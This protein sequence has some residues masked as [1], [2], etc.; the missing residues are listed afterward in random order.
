V[1]STALCIAAG[2]LLTA[3]A[4]GPDYQRPKVESPGEWRI[5]YP[6]AAEV[7]NTRWWQQFGDPAL[8]Q[9]VETA[10][11]E[12][13]DVQ[14]ASARVDQFLGVLST[15]RS[16][17]FPQFGYSGDASRNRASQVGPTPISGT[18]PNYSLYQGSLNAAWQ[19]DLFGRV[20]R[21][22]E[23]AQAQVYASEQGR[24]GVIL[25]IVT[26]TATNYV[27]LRSLDRQLEIAQSSARNYADTKELFQLR[28]KGGV[29]SEV[30]LAQIESQYQLA[31]AT[32]PSLEQ[33]IAAQENL[34]SVLLGRNPGAI[35]R[36]KSIDE[37]VPPAIPAGL[38]SELL[39]RRPDILQAEQ[40]LVAVNAN[41]GVAKSLYFPSISITGLFGSLSTAAGDF[42]GPARPGP[43]GQV[44]WAIFTFGAISG[45]VQTAEAA[46]VEAMLFYRS[47]ILNA[48]RETSDAL[49]GSQKKLEEAEAQAR[50]VR[51]LR[52]YAR[53]ARLRFDNGASSYIEVLFA[54]NDLFSAELTSVSTQAERYTQLIN[55]YKAMGGG[56]GLERSDGRPG[57][58]TK[59]KPN[60]P[61][62]PEEAAKQLALELK[63]N[64][65]PPGEGDRAT[66]R[67]VDAHAGAAIRTGRHPAARA[68]FFSASLPSENAGASATTR[69][70]RACRRNK[71]SGSAS[72]CSST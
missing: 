64:P 10:L 9:L 49:I 46:Q 11:R 30:E 40:N 54:E 58:G 57:K 37:L 42:T 25:S 6:K 47:T 36:G 48:F 4:V 56:C 7:A 8:D 43:S 14:A 65:D 34:I 29:V 5:D 66:G 55:V 51:A 59:M 21:Q 60:E 13:L 68:F 33:Q 19:I 26:T 12:N 3:C 27:V 62:Y 41:I 23:A 70:S 15:T 32:I 72:S 61:R 31:L 35:P 71:V 52:D 17:F 16:Q 24:R 28:F 22:S 20:R 53:L 39:E 67:A 63:D 1:R 69:S 44:R 18:N 50:R 2:A 45:Q 38:P